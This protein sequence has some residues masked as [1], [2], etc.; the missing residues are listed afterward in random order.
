MN[1]KNMK[2]IIILDVDGVLNCDTTTDRMHIANHYGELGK[3]TGIDDDKIERLRKIIN[4]TDAYIVISST[5]RLIPDAMVYLKEKMGPSLSARI[6]GSTDT[7]SDRMSIRYEEVAKWLDKHAEDVLSFIVIDDNPLCNLEK[8][9]DR[10]IQT[11]E[12]I[13]LTDKDVSK[14]IEKLLV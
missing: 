3:Y 8:F 5:W 6:I 7:L 1:H 13:G 12:S 2:K 11:K 14:C 4:A 10:F 9:G